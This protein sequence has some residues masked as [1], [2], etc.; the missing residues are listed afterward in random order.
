MTTD[1]A[2]S[3]PPE[4]VEEIRA[5]RQRF[6]LVGIAAL[7]VAGAGAIFS[8]DQF[9]R[10]Y[11]WSY[12]FFVGVT[13]GCVAFAMLQHLT[14][15]AWG[16]VIVRLCESAARTLPLLAVLFVPVA[17]GIPRLY[18]WS[19]PEAVAAD[20][21]LRHKSVYL[22][23]PF[24]LARTAFYFAGWCLLAYLLNKWSAWQDAGRG[25]A[26][27]RRLRV[28]SSAG[29]LFYGYSVTFMCVDW[30]MSLDP[31]WF[32]TIFGML[33]IVGQGLSA[34]AFL[35]T[36]LVILSHRR[37][38]AGVLQASHIH[39]IGKLLLAFVMLWAYL[40]FSQFLIIWSGNLP[41]EIPW[42]LERLRGGWQYICLG[43]VFLH[44]TLP[45]ALLLSRDL[46]RNYRLLTSVAV[47]IL[48]MRFVD[49]YW[50]VA[51]DFRK[52]GFGASWMD[53]VIPVGL[54]GVWLA[55]FAWQLP[56]RPLLPLHD[57]NLERALE[58]GR[59]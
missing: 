20:E 12:I 7:A 23:T 10:S 57:P 27:E 28:V 49:L 32:S 31:H 50:L 46:K 40:S 44:F 35:I 48:A 37:P 26:A 25:A 56:R 47:L 59:E 43:L 4:L 34:L 53:L 1:L 29:L 58:H 6:L 21:A 5:W 45:F 55:A 52:G 8:P 41:E 3:T 36:V 16:A 17:V 15:G 54:G 18:I 14:G 13:L 11:L 9:F 39:D 33:F 22:N 30:V 42:Y 51:P 38:F 2:L 24:F 19:H